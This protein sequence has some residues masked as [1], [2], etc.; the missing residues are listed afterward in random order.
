MIDCLS[1]K[2]WPGFCPSL[3]IYRD[4]GVIVDH[5]NR[6]QTWPVEVPVCAFYLVVRGLYKLKWVTV[7]YYSDYEGHA[8]NPL[9]SCTEVVYKPSNININTDQP[10][11]SHSLAS[12]PTKWPTLLVYTLYCQ[13]ISWHKAKEWNVLGWLVLTLIIGRCV[14]YL[15]FGFILYICSIF[16]PGLIGC[17]CH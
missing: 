2:A 16:V 10:G 8:F 3:I 15:S 1:D 11:T 5:S 6:V 4:V 14:D 9:T 7:L 17:L 12:W 13:L